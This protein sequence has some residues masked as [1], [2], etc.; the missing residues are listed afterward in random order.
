MFMMDLERRRELLDDLIDKQG[1]DS[2]RE[3]KFA[4]TKSVR[5]NDIEIDLV[6][7]CRQP[8]A[9]KMSVRRRETH[10]VR[11]RF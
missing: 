9:T 5:N 4:K 2:M 7:L 8:P 3:D 1:G 6:A 11:T 10:I